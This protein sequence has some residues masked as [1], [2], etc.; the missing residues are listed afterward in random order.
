MFYFSF[1]PQSPQSLISVIEFNPRWCCY[2]CVPAYTSVVSFA[3]RFIFLRNDKCSLLCVHDFFGF[4]V[5]ITPSWLFGVG[6]RR[7]CRDAAAAR[8]KT[9]L[10]ILFCTSHVYVRKSNWNAINSVD[11]GINCAASTDDSATSPQIPPLNVCR[12]ERM[13]RRNNDAFMFLW[14]PYLPTSWVHS[15]CG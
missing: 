7:G 3:V 1:H 13:I 12:R 14:N 11:N 5:W 8:S 4:L 10:D 15:N 6:G 2:T 9:L